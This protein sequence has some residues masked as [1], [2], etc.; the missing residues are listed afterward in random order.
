MSKISEPGYLFIHSGV[1]E[2]E[3]IE[4]SL[5]DCIEYIHQNYDKDFRKTNF[6]INVVKNKDGMK[7]GHTYAWIEN[8]ELFNSLIGKDFDGSDLFEWVEDKEW[9][10][11]EKSYEEAMKEAGDDWGAWDDVERAYKRPRKKVPLEPLVSLPAI[12]YTPSQEKEINYESKFGFLELLPIKLSQKFGKLNVLFTN[13]IPKWITEEL[14]FDYFKK[15]ERDDRFHS[16]KKSKKKFQYPLVKIKSK[17]DFRDM[18][19]FCT[20]TFSSMYPQTASFLIN[21]VKRLELEEGDNKALLFFSQSKS[22]NQEI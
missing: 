22:K 6:L 17:K 2:K 10:P 13:D 8:K 5:S 19:R 20:I 9:N 7:F 4:K 12:K 14:I 18:R 3:Q 15:F 1:L 11:P 21:V 16:D